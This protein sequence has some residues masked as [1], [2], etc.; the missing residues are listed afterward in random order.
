MAIRICGMQISFKLFL[1]RG[2]SDEIS[3]E[4]VSSL[5]CGTERNN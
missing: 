5:I 4:A 3:D 2:P 1:F